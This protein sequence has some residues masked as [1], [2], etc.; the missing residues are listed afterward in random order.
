MG[1]L[2]NLAKDV[3]WGSGPK[4][5]FD[6]NYIKKREGATQ[7]YSITVSCQPLSGSHYFGYPIYVQISLDGVSKTTFT[8]KKASPS[9]WSSSIIYYTGWLSVTNKTSGTTDLKIRVYSGSGSSRDKTYNYTLDI[10]QPASAIS[11]TEAAVGS[12]PVISIS[13]A[14]S[15]FTHTISYEFGSLSGV[16]AELTSATQITDWTIPTSFYAEIPHE[17]S[18]VGTLTCATYNGSTLLG[19]TTCEFPVTTNESVCKPNVSG[20]VVDTNPHTVAVTGDED[21]LVRY[22]STAL[23]TLTANSRY[24]SVLRAKKINGT[25]TADNTLT[26]E[27]VEIDT[28]EFYALD[29]RGYHNTVKVV[30]PLVPYIRLTA[31]VTAWRVDPTSGRAVLKVEGNCFKGSFGAKDNTLTIQ[32]R[33]G[34]GAYETL[35][36]TIADDNTYSV[37][38]SLSGL[39]YTKSFDYE[40]VVFDELNSI[41]KTATILKGIPVFDWGEEDFNF[42][43]P[44]TIK[45]VNILEKLAELEALLAS[46]G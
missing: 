7:Y 35:T 1:N 41:P 21:I 36:P 28:F 18:K 31:N 8:I 10:D 22:C 38:I 17:K 9:Q 33:Q 14:S 44:V 12:R 29:S 42:N 24:S 40:V 19:T 5:Y 6:F 11:C 2:S 30:K 43:V 25:N 34:E 16:I 37:S 4:I 27:N 3:Q 15:N 13:R 39:D 20:N 26:I 46:K 45:G 23:C 32:Y